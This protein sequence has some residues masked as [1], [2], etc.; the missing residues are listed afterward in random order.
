MKIHAKDRTL[1]AAVVMTAAAVIFFAMLQ[2]RWSSQVRE[3]TGVR[4]ADT[5]QLSMVNWHLDL[6]RTFSEVSLMMRIDP[7]ND[8]QDVASRYAQRLAEWRGV[9]NYPDLVSTIRLLRVGDAP[10]RQALRLNT[11]TRRFEAGDWPPELATWRHELAKASPTAGP[12]ALGP[13]PGGQ[14]E[15]LQAH[16]T[17]QR[18]AETF[19]GLAVRGWLFEPSV[20]ALLHSIAY[21]VANGAPRLDAGR[22]AAGWI[23][24]ELSEAVIRTKILPDLAYRYFQGTDGLDYEVAVVTGG[25]PRHVIYSSDPGFGDDEV[26]DADGTLDVFGHVRNPAV[27][28]AVHV[29]HTT[30]PV[31]VQWFPLL[32]DTPVEHDWQ[33]VVRHRR[34]GP[35]GAFVAD[36]HRRDLV[37]SFGA[38][39]LLVASM[40]MLI[41]TSMRAQRLARSQMDFVTVVSHDLRTPLSV[42]SAAAD[43]IA[44]GVV[45]GTDQ[46]KQYGSVISTQVRQLSARVEQILLFAATDTG[47]QRYSAQPLDVSEIVDAALATTEG[48]IRAARFT[49]ERKLDPA[50]PKVSGDLLALSQCLQNLIANAL[51]YGREGAWIGIRAELVEN[52][53]HSREVQISVSDRG[54]GI[55]AADLAHIFEPFYRGGAVA[56]A[57]IRGTGLGLALATRIAEAMKGRLTAASELGRGSTFTLHLPCA[58]A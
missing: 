24:V 16:A 44:Q 32:R 23:V 57:Q 29:F 1:S 35:L 5:L 8:P 54:V 38:L 53:P 48:S 37:I 27:G 20:P 13:G 17:N 58:D 18:L 49:V 3:A 51:K 21:E 31:G 43:N 25:A 39:L 14:V 36:M 4:L 7:E 2:Y 11:S 15:E 46:L 26:K 28:S 55:Q 22:A 52:G 30:S 56:D 10:D 45:T 19:V 47:A 33:L 9:A 41:I 40:T 50:L 34:G 12:A 42:I 6:L